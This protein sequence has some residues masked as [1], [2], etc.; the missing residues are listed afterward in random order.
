MSGM[1]EGIAGGT[2]DE[3]MAEAAIRTEAWIEVVPEDEADGLL[4][5]LYERE[6]VPQTGAVDNILKIH[7]LHPE[8]LRDHAELYKT[9]MFGKGG[10]SRPEREMIGLIV[11]AVNHCYYCLR[12]HAV[13]LGR[14]TERTRPGFAEGVERDFAS[15]DMTPRERAISD[16][17][18]K[19]TLT[20]WEMRRSDLQPMRDEGLSDG[21]ILDANLTA[22]YYAYVNRIADGLGV[23]V[24]GGDEKIGW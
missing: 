3:L 22:S 6:R 8:T 15:A 4:A 7:S 17:V 12:H 5:E 9:L 23:G 13:S 10:L 14:L 1:H 24:E 18:V 19:L 21:D 20:P 16:Y 2:D 11:S